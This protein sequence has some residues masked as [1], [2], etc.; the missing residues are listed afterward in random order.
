MVPK[1]TYNSMMPQILKAGA[2]TG[3]TTIAI[4]FQDGDGDI[5]FDTYNLYLKDSRDS[6]IIKMKIPS[7]PAEYSP[8]KGLKG[9]ITI[10]YLAALLTLRPDT[11]HIESDTLH[12]EIYLKDEAG[13][14]S[15]TIVTDD[16][17]LLK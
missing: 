9:T 12:W 10:D 4:Y 2:S 1:I 8:E 15:N 14:I 11:A 6:S 17:L 16:L 5:G 7:I 3:G 13:N